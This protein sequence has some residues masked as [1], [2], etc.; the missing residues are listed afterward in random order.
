MRSHHI[1]FLLIGMLLGCKKSDRLAWNLVSAPKVEQLSV[2]SNSITSFEL[3]AQFTSSGHDPKAQFGFCFSTNNQNPTI[4]DQVIYLSEGMEGVGTTTIPWNTTAPLF[5][6]AFIKNK[7]ATVYSEFLLVIWPGNAQN[8]PNIGNVFCINVQ[9]YQANLSCQVIYDGGLPI[10]NRG[11]QI[12]KSPTFVGSTLSTI[13]LNNGPSTFNYEFENLEEN[14][15]YFYRAFATNMVGTTYSSH[16]FFVTDNFYQIGEVGPA[17]GI[18]FYHKTD[19]LDGWNFLECAPLDIGTSKVFATSNQ[20]T[21]IPNL[22][23]GLGKGDENTA[24]ILSAIG[25]GNNAAKACQTYTVNGFSDWYLPTRDELIKLY[26]NLLPLNQGGLSGNT[27]WSS[28]Q[29]PVYA[30][31]AWVQTMQQVPSGTGT[32]TQQKTTLNRVRP[33]RCF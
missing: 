26:Q 7:V 5:C 4:N 12:C 20:L 29:D 24:V 3:S 30:Q 15:C 14:T 17:G 33:V 19:T 32:Y 11:F 28:N 22:E 31:N 6:R 1:V 10:I 8:K 2:K 16:S 25:N 13:N 23:Y 9:F 21:M 27:Y 18:I